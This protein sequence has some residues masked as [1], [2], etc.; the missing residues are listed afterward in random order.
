MV[1]R[2]S[3]PRRIDVE[4]DEVILKIAEDNDISII[5]ATRELAKISKNNLK[6]LKREIV[7]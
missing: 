3:I 4:L 5:Q 1:R 7:F 6:G 2:N